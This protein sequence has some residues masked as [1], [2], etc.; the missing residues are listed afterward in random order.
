MELVLDICIKRKDLIKYEYVL[1]VYNH[2][3]L[4]QMYHRDL[5]KHLP[6][7]VIKLLILCYLNVLQVLLLYEIYLD[8]DMKIG[9]LQL[10]LIIFLDQI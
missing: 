3:H 10:F 8:I 2:L 4:K 6:A 1:L 9:K 7:K 5:Y